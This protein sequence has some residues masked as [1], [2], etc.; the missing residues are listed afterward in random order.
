MFEVSFLPVAV[1]AACRVGECVYSDVVQAE[2]FAVFV[3]CQSQV[4]CHISSIGEAT[5]CFVCRL[6]WDNSG[7]GCPGHKSAG[8]WSSTNIACRSLQG[9]Y[10]C[11]GDRASWLVLLFGFGWQCQGSLHIEGHPLCDELSPWLPPFAC[12]VLI[13]RQRFRLPV[14]AARTSGPTLLLRLTVP[15]CV[16]ALMPT[17]CSN[18]ITA[19]ILVVVLLISF[20]S[21]NALGRHTPGLFVATTIPSRVLLWR[22][23]YIRFYVWVELVFCSKYDRVLFPYPLCVYVL[24]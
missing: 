20:L 22:P 18:V 17:V 11:T 8:S 21:E 14:C 12:V 10:A 9:L 4:H 1:I 16:L 13:V 7:N 3:A 2:G 5:L 24:G 23:L 19:S 15:V 6:G